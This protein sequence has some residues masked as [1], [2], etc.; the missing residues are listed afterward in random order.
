MVG[1][2]LPGHSWRPLAAQE[3]VEVKEI[4]EPGGE[5]R[6][7]LAELPARPE[8][9]GGTDPRTGHHGQEFDGT[10]VVWIHPAGKGSLFQAGKLIPAAQ[11]IVDKKAAIFAPDLFLT[12]EFQPAK[13]PAV[14]NHYAGF[15]FGYNRCCSPTVSTTF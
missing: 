15:T 10:V 7:R 2:A 4:G 8:G 5:E 9:Q 14:D 6:V 13:P 1:A 11:Q 12:G 3:E